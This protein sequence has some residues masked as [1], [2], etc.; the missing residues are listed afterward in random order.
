[1][2]EITCLAIS[3]RRMNLTTDGTERHGWEEWGLRL[4]VD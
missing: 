4:L 1:M 3:H 2:I